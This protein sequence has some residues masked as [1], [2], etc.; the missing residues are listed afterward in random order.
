MSRTRR[1]SLEGRRVLRRL[2]W[3]LLLACTG[4]DQFFPYDKEPYEV[5]GVADTVVS[6]TGDT[7]GTA[8]LCVTKWRRAQ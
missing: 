3:A 8:Q 5:C 6:T 4:C 7:L 1:R 2:A